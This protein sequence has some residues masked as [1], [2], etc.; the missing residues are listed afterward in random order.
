VTASDSG[1]PDLDS[2]AVSP[3]VVL[4]LGGSLITEKDRPETLDEPALDAACDAIAAALADGAVDRLVIV[5]GGWELRSP[6]RE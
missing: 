4:K 5:H 1:G 6:P 3:P 2:D